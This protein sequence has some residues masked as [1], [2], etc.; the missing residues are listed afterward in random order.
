MSINSENG[1]CTFGYVYSDNRCV[2]LVKVDLKDLRVS[3]GNN[4][5][6]EPFKHIVCISFDLGNSFVSDTLRPRWEI[7]EEKGVIICH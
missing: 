3:L 5:S 7:P 4:T 2:S 6:R 1:D